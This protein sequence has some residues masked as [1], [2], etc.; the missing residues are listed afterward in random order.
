MA[1]TYK[2]TVWLT[3]PFSA[4]PVSEMETLITELISNY[5]NEI[6]GLGFESVEVGVIK[7]GEEAK[8]TKYLKNV[9]ADIISKI[10]KYMVAQE[11]DCTLD[12]IDRKGINYAFLFR[13][14]EEGHHIWWEVIQGNYEPFYKFWKNNKK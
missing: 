8:F 2:A 13:N 10:K 7:D 14:T 3:S 11:S 4:I 9:P 12:Y 5:R 6:T 1:T